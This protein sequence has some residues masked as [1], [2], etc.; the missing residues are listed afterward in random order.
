MNFSGLLKQLKKRLLRRR[1]WLS[2][3]SWLLLIG[4]GITVFMLLSEDQNPLPNVIPVTESVEGKQ[5]MNPESIP[6]NPRE[7]VLLSLRNSTGSKNVMVKALYV[8]GEEMQHIGRLKASDIVK[9]LEDNQAWEARFDAGGN[10]VMTHHVEDLSPECKKNAYMGLDANGN[11]TMFDGKPA[12]QKTIRTF[13]QMNIQHLESSLPQET[14]QELRT[15]I[16]ISDLAEYNSV[17]STFSDY[18]LEETEKVMKPSQ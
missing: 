2:P 14:V 4:A 17:L 1:R 10:V 12:E 7:E 16:R 9:K 13:F 11:L 5:M 8:C 15:G 3:I 6:A 18:A